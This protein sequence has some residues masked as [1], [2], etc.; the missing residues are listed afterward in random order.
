MITEIAEIEVVPGHEYAFEIAVGKA[1]LLFDAAPGCRGMELH[2][3][4]ETPLRYRLLVRWDSIEAHT[5]DFR[6]SPAFQR[7]RELAGPHFAAPPVVE[8]GD[9]V[10][11]G[12]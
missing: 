3:S 2:R 10:V 6:G 5:V 4:I 8:H 7:W 12:F 1:R 9:T 11:G